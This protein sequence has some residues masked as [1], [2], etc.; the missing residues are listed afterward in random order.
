M[1][2]PALKPVFQDTIRAKDEFLFRGILCLPGWEKSPSNHSVNP[3]NNRTLLFMHKWWGRNS[4]SDY[5]LVDG[6]GIWAF[7]VNLK[8]GK[9]FLIGRS[10]ESD[11]RLPDA[12]VSGR[13]CQ[14]RFDDGAW[15]LQD[16]QST[17]HLVN[18]NPSRVP[19]RDARVPVGARTLLHSPVP[20]GREKAWD[21]PGAERRK[22]RPARS[23]KK[24]RLARW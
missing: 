22:D 10:S 14:L 20:D 15:I 17:R 19:A 16:L 21:K 3:G 9:S 24:P 6:P 23:D 5:L 18:A 2:L 8:P 7:Q 1:P 13:H 4:M 12:K 11:L